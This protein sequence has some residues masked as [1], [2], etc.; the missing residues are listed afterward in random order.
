MEQDNNDNTY[1]NFVVTRYKKSSEVS[2]LKDIH[3]AL[4]DKYYQ[5]ITGAYYEIGDTVNNS[6]GDSIGT[7]IDI[8]ECDIENR[9]GLYALIQLIAPVN[10]DTLIQL[11]IP[12]ENIVFEYQGWDSGSDI[13]YFPL[14]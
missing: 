9:E 10:F 8:V 14:D 12:I 11:G 13:E 5:D 7:I 2:W 3:I 4:T 6:L 1:S